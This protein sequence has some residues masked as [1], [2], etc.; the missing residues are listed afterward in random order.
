MWFTDFNR[1]VQ[2]ILENIP[3]TKRHRMLFKLTP[4][5]VNNTLEI[6]QIFKPEMTVRA[7]FYEGNWYN[8]Q[9]IDHGRWILRGR[10][11]LLQIN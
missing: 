3:P 6:K 4:F 7:D 2:H 11:F 8:F 10:Q 5:D 1:L 9:E